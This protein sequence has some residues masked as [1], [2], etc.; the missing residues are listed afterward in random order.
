MISIIREFF[1]RRPAG[2]APA[3]EPI[4]P[5]DPLSH[6]ALQRMTPA[7]LADLPLART[8]HAGGQAGRR[9]ANA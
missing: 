7:E 3:C 9:H 2:S 6:P 4:W 5:G 8:R 1:T